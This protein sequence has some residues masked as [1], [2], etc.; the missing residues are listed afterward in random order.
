VWVRELHIRGSQSWEQENGEGL[1]PVLWPLRVERCSVR[2]SLGWGGYFIGSMW[3]GG[4]CKSAVRMGLYPA[5]VPGAASCAHEG[6]L[7]WRDWFRAQGQGEGHNPAWVLIVC[8]T[9]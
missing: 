7:Q 2:G 3:R 8:D 1:N 9:M 6:H 5:R 4:S